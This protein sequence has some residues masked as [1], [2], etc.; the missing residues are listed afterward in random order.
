MT[1]AS[2]PLDTL[3]A[4]QQVWR[5]RAQARPVHR[6]YSTG[7]T[8]LDALLPS[9]GWPEHGLVE[10]L[11]D[12]TGQGELSL[13]LPTLANLSTQARPILAIAPP[14]CPYAP[15]WQK[16]GVR[17]AQ[18]HVVEATGTDALWA[19]EQALRAGCCSAVLGWPKSA[20]DKAL[21]RLQVAAD[22]GNTLGFIF[23]AL[24][25]AR[26]PSPAPLRLC[27]EYQATGI[28]LRVLKCRGSAPPAGAV[29]LRSAR[30]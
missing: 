28:A 23:R 12:A 20:D 24:A 30:H 13:L 5:G 22:S 2:A 4:N 19:M 17:L 8:A 9:Q 29:A 21:R 3:L 1:T 18:L 26:N 14:F 25:M 7:L 6:P 10:V 15:A 27:I 16:A 11:S